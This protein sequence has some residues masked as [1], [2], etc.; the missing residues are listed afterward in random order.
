MNKWTVLSVAGLVI[1]GM[2]AFWRVST[3]SAVSEH[4]SQHVESGGARAGMSLSK[5]EAAFEP[6]KG[7]DLRRSRQRSA[8]LAREAGVGLRGVVTENAQAHFTDAEIEALV[9]LIDIATFAFDSGDTKAY[10]RYYDI[11]GFTLPDDWLKPSSPYGFVLRGRKVGFASGYEKAI[12]PKVLVLRV[13]GAEIRSE[14][15][16][17]SGEER[18]TICYIDNDSL[19]GPHDIGDPIGAAA[20]LVRV[21]YPGSQIR[22]GLRGEG[23]VP[24]TTH[25]YFVKRPADTRWLLWKLWDTYP[26]GHGSSEGVR[27]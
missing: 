25:L 8:N 4:A 17:P 19:R 6:L 13:A 10:E 18:S 14:P 20:H 2:F 11:Q 5:R 15:P 9:A 12:Q 22:V 24:G 27:L 7:S 16:P 3:K 21:S 1:L 23:F 26:R